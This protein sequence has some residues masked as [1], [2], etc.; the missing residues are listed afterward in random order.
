[1]RSK[2][3]KIGWSH[4][5]ILYLRPIVQEKKKTNSFLFIRVSVHLLMQITLYY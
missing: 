4:R 3:L 5:N 1:M 2:E